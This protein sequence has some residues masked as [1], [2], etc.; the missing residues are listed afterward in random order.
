MT[1]LSG[2]QTLQSPRG[3]STLTRL[4]F[5][6]TPNQNRRASQASVSGCMRVLSST[7]VM[8]RVEESAFFQPYS[9]LACIA[10]GIVVRGID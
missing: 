8:V 6:C 2:E 3:F 5:L 7:Q 9:L 4:C 1:V 10:S